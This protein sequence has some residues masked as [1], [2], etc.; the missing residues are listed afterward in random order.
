[1]DDQLLPIPSRSAHPTLVTFKN[2][3]WGRRLA[4]PPDRGRDRQAS[5]AAATATH[6]PARTFNPNSVHSAAIAGLA[7]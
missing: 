6:T 4:W 1:M 3:A 5:S 2:Q 7:Q